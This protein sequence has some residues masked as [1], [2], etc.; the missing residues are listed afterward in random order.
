MQS[1]E[2]ESICSHCPIL[3]HCQDLGCTE[4]M[5]IYCAP[6]PWPLR[7][8][9]HHCCFPVLGWKRK[10]F[11]FSL[12]LL[13]ATL[14]WAHRLEFRSHMVLF[15]RYRHKHT[16]FPQDL[17]ACPPTS[18]SPDFQQL[19]HFLLIFCANH[20]LS[21]DK[22]YFSLGKLHIITVFIL[23]QKADGPFT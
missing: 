20:F 22:S 3:P 13:R 4:Y 18:R 23:I 7:K 15:N 8:W 9:C 5:R 21:Q 11:F 19:R 6:R 10:D 1:L 16:Y 14:T 12:S 2:T 17:P